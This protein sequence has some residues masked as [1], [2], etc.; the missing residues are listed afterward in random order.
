MDRSKILN[1]SKKLG[2]GILSG[3]TPKTVYG[4]IT[5]NKMI[6]LFET[7]T[8]EDIALISFIVPMVN[9]TKNL[10]SLYN[11]LPSKM[12]SF[13]ICI[14]SDTEVYNTCSYCGGSGSDTCR[15]CDGSG[16]SECDYCEGGG[17]DEEG[18][19]CDYCL[20]DGTI[21]CTCEGSGR[22]DC[23][24]CGGSG[25]ILV[26]D[27]R[28]VNVDKW[29]SWD[30]EIY[31]LLELTDDMSEINSDLLEKIETS[32]KSLLMLTTYEYTDIFVSDVIKDDVYFIELNKEL[33]LQKFGRDSITDSNLEGI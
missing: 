30:E 5:K 33:S 32:N 6:P 17:E 4:T 23:S 15:E 27:E 28:Q 1:F 22:E 25:D 13:T 3:A 11:T 16:D 31:N 8:A 29:L 18:E 2:S 9:T 21:D 10:E 12:F 14:I 24:K 7:L 26:E 20:G 19:T